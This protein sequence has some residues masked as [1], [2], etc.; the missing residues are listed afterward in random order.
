MDSDTDSD[1]DQDIADKEVIPDK[2][3][4]ANN[5]NNGDKSKID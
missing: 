3:D 1:E 5:P 2:K 4:I